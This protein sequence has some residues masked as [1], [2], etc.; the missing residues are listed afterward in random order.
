MTTLV[1]ILLERQGTIVE[2]TEMVVSFFRR[3]CLRKIEF[4]LVS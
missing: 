2:V 1:S 3:I 4:T